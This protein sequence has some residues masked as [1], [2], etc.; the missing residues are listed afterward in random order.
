MTAGS[1]KDCKILILGLLIITGCSGFRNGLK[2]EIEQK[3]VFLTTEYY[4]FENRTKFFSEP[5]KAKIDESSAVDSVA[6]LI[7]EQLMHSYP[8][9]THFSITGDSTSADL[10]VSVSNIRLRR[11]IYSIN[12][13]HIG[14][15]YD[16][17]MEVQIRQKKGGQFKYTA[18][19]IANMAW[20][21]FD[22]RIAYWMT[23]Q[24][25]R[26]TEYQHHNYIIALKRAFYNLYIHLFRYKPHIN[27]ATIHHSSRRDG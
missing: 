27:E 2:P 19:S 26:N 17:K 12:F 5:T 14:P 24:E 8:Q 16:V 7:L 18:R 10:I 21:N 11:R 6:S 22:H 1:L 3:K 4:E 20:E 23:P 25:K 9:F 15:L 13:L